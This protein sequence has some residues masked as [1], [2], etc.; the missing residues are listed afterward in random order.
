MLGHVLFLPLIAVSVAI[1][2]KI[3]IRRRQGW[4]QSGRPGWLLPLVGAPVSGAT[5]SK[6]PAACPGALARG[7][8][9]G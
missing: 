6:A 1:T 7:R 8:V 3:S 9:R 4:G 2:V 5:S